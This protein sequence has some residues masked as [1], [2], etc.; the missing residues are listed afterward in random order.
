MSQDWT[1]RK[2]VGGI[3]LAAPLVSSLAKAATNAPV[4]TQTP[5]VLASPVLT[6]TELRRWRVPEANQAAAVDSAHF[7][8]IGNRTLVKHRKS[9]GVR[10]AEWRGAEDGP[11]VHFNAGYV[12][13]Q[14]L[15]LAH[16]NFSQ[17]PMASSL[18]TYDTATMQPVATHSFGIRLGSLTWAVRHRGFWWACFA[19]YNDKGTTPGFDQRWTHF[20][21]FDDAWQLRQSWLFPPKI[22]AT[23]GESSCSGGDWGDDGLLYITGHDAPELYA[24]RL[25]RQGVV[26]DHVATIA[27]PFEGQGWA[28]DRSVRRERI[29]YGISRQLKDVVVARIPAL[30]RALL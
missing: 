16:S 17:L 25:P 20:G 29:I 12:D 28:W 3:A 1:R 22:I 24:L 2:L 26:L 23:W 14:R 4:A 7:Y 18:E 27:V 6:A 15:V 21:Q 8:G 9:D 10:V 13:R 30:P 19:N 5:P 11:I